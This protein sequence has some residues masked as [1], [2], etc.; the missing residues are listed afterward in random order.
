VSLGLRVL[1][2]LGP[3]QQLVITL[4][5]V[6]LQPSRGHPALASPQLV[7]AACGGHVLQSA[8]WQCPGIEAGEA[9]LVTTGE[10]GH[11]VAG[12]Q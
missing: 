4:D 10:Q 8:P 5:T 3:G 12:L 6:S 9:S 1:M 7:S 2:A 11:G